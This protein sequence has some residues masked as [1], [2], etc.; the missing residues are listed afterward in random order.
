MQYEGVLPTALP[1]G[2][3]FALTRTLPLSLRLVPNGLVTARPMLSGVEDG[4]RAHEARP[5]HTHRRKQE[6][7][8]FSQPLGGLLVESWVS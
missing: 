7:L 5:P 6:M 2:V 8:H 1:L 4:I 3:C